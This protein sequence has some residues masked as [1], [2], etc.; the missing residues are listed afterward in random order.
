MAGRSERAERPVPYP[1]I[2]YFF[3]RGEDWPSG[4]EDQ[5][6]RKLIWISDKYTKIRPVKK[7]T[8]V[9][10]NR[11]N[12]FKNIY[13]KYY[14]KNGPQLRQNPVLD[15]ANH[16]IAITYIRV[17]RLW[18]FL[19]DLI[20]PRVDG[21]RK[22]FFVRVSSRRREANASR[23]WRARVWGRRASVSRNTADGG[24]EDFVAKVETVVIGP[25]VF[26]LSVCARVSSFFI[27]PRASVRI[28]IVRCGRCWT[29]DSPRHSVTLSSTRRVDGQCGALNLSAAIRDAFCTTT[30]V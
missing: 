19:V 24:R 16:A 12:T 26:S 11:R 9:S 29:T 22:I 23:T 28:H 8:I 27:Y 18:L 6:N 14:E 1:G 3:G 20:T 5:I 30:G 13:I 10:S 4:L 7:P 25:Y 21:N 2:F 15:T 17:T